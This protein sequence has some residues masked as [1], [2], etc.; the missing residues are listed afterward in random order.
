MMSF[1]SIL[2]S[3][4]FLYWLFYTIDQKN[5]EIKNLRL[6]YMEARQKCEELTLLIDNYKDEINYHKKESEEHKAHR[7]RLAE[8]FMRPNKCNNVCCRK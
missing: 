5:E 7:E 6:L 8:I 1:F 3:I 2:F 4:I